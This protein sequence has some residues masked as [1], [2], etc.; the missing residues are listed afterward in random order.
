MRRTAR[1]EVRSGSQKEEKEALVA[2][3]Q[4]V[5][6]RGAHEDGQGVVTN[7]QVTLG[8]GWLVFGF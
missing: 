6:V 3:R 2:L 8:K 1:I 7:G 5:D 4:I